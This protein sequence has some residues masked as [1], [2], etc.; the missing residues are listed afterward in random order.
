M[1]WRSLASHRYSTTPL[2]H[3]PERSLVNGSLETIAGP[4]YSGKTSELSRR[5]R[6]EQIAGLKALVLQA[7][8]QGER[9]LRTAARLPELGVP[10]LPVRSAAEICEQVNAAR[11]RPDVVALDNAH[12]LEPEAA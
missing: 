5:V 7:S 4:V 10:V 8:A 6:R 3:S 9:R 2:L 11:A 1:E 12:E